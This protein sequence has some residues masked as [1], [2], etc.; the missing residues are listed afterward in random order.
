M[1]KRPYDGS[2]D[3][4]LHKKHRNNGTHDQRGHHRQ[5]D[6]RDQ[7]RHDDNHQRAPPTS[8]PPPPQSQISFDGALGKLP[9]S[10]APLTAVP[11]YVPFTV[12][13]HLPAAPD[14]LD[15]KLQ[16]AAFTH[17]SSLVNNRRNETTEH[18]S[19]ERLEFLGDAYLELF[20]SRL[21]MDRVGHLGAGP[22]SQLRELLVKNETLAEYARMYEFEKRVSAS[23]HDVMRMQKGL[24]AELKGN[25]GFNK[26][27]GD[28]F[29]AY[30]AAVVMS[31]PENGFAV[32][33]KWLTTLWAPKLVTALEGDKLWDPN[34]LVHAQDGDPKRRYDPEAKNTL[35][36]RVGNGTNGVK[37]EYEQYA[38]MQEL[39]GDKKGQNRFFIAVYLTGHGYHKHLLGKGEGKSKVEAGIW[40]AMEAMHGDSKDVVDACEQKV[41]QGKAA[42]AA[43][44]QEARS[45]EQLG[46]QEK[47]NDGGEPEKAD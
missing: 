29:E 8:A 23:L 19:Y 28:V 11:G 33:E 17:V 42:R 31:D 20:A 45:K 1:N 24:K 10:T 36:R 39:K 12:P 47:T 46:K 35:Q 41:Q 37:V 16:N 3:R 13:K 32:A 14:I 40:A 18:V 7:R 44:A 30:V 15:P 43:A 6:H 34:S 21:I 25:K 26:I 9:A 5:Q 27:L 2:G 22:M 38:P 4:Q